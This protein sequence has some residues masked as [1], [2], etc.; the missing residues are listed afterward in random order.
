MSGRS[1][2]RST[3]PAP[4]RQPHPR[5]ARSEHDEGCGLGDEARDHAGATSTRELA[6]GQTPVDVDDGRA[7]EDAA[8]AVLDHYES[9]ATAAGRHGTLRRVRLRCDRLSDRIW[10]RLSIS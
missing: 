10:E 2:P 4:T 5:Q 1:L 7:P 8:P 3:R 6:A 9:A